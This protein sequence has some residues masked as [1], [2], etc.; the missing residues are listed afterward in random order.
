MVVLDAKDVIQLLRFEVELAGGPTAFS[1]KARVDRATVH[2]ALKRQ[3]RPSRKIICALDLRVVYMPK[4]D[5]L[6]AS[7]SAKEGGLNEPPIE[8]PIQESVVPK[9]G[10]NIVIV[11]SAAGLRDGK[12]LLFINGNSVKAPRAQVALVACLYSELGC[13]VPYERLCRVIGHQSSRDRQMHILRQHML[14]VR[15]MLAT[16]KARCF[17]AVAPDVGYALCEVAQA[18]G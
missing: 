8:L 13:V 11:P 10:P 4:R 2:R 5:K 15:R 17:L 9:R 7:G 14:L 1:K 3:E 18:Q 6:K 12:L 16:H